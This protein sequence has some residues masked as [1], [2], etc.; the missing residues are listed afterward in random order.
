MFVNGL[1][2]SQSFFENWW[3]YLF[4]SSI[5]LSLVFGIKNKWIGYVA[6]GVVGVFGTLKLV[7]WL[8]NR[9]R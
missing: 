8:K 5:G 7:R 2:K 3:N 4:I 6:I 1:K 9:K